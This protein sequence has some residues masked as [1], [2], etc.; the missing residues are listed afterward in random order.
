VF[1]ED[2]L[3]T[4]HKTMADDAIKAKVRAPAGIRLCLPSKPPPP[5]ATSR[6]STPAMF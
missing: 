5:L 3:L 1:V 4:L 2:R 6:V